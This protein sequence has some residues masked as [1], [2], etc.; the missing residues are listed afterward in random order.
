MKSTFEKKLHY[1]A[2][3]IFLIGLIV[4]VS[5]SV[6]DPFIFVDTD[7]ISRVSGSSG[8]GSSSSSSGNDCNNA[9]S[10][11]QKCVN[12]VCVWLEKASYGPCTA[13][14]TCYFVGIPFEYNVPGHGYHCQK[15]PLG[16]TSCT[17]T[18][19]PDTH[20]CD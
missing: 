20:P 19:E 11:G 14:V 3:G 1:I 15:H 13:K 12:G 7:V 9:C 16:A 4:N 5:L 10:P 2:A 6:T 17:V 8:S 18:C